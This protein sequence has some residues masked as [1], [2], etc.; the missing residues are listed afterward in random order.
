[1][2]A[3]ELESSLRIA[4]VGSFD[5]LKWKTDDARFCDALERMGVS[6]VRLEGDRGPLHD[7]GDVAPID[8]VVFGKRPEIS[9]DDMS[10]ARTRTGAKLA[11]VLFDLMD[12]RERAIR[13]VPFLTRCRLDWWIPQARTLDVVFMKEQGNLDRYRSMGVNCLYLDQGVDPFETPLQPP[14]SKCFDVSFFGRW[15]E[16]RQRML[17]AISARARVRVFSNEVR[18]WRSSRLQVGPPVYGEQFAEAVARSI[19][20]WGESER[21]DIDGYWSD[22]RYRVMGRAGCFVTRYTPG[23]DRVFTNDQNIVWY[24]DDNEAVQRVEYYLQNQPEARAIGE[25]AAN[26]VHRVHR[27]DDRGRTPPPS[28]A[29]WRWWHRRSIGSS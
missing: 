24:Q 21:H 16:R 10:A 14:A 29:I 9:P 18:R 5:N 20:V 7:L 25:A 22:R 15:T 19:L 11:Q 12:F 27:Y 13:G 17:E 28:G 6:V 3:F 23:V 4:W 8:W 1:M 2:P 26:L